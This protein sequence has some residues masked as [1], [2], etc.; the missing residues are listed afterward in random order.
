MNVSRSQRL[1]YLFSLML[2]LLGSTVSVS[3]ISETALEEIIVTAQRSEE[4]LQDVPIAVTAL[5]GDMLQ[6][7][8]VINPSDLQMQGCRFTKTKYNTELI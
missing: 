8:G 1:P 7:K 6:D 5:T 4:S 2:G 3:A